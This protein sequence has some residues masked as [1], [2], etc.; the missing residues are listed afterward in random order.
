MDAPSARELLP[1]T[2]QE[3]YVRKHPLVINAPKRRAIF[4]FSCS[5]FRLQSPFWTR[6]VR[7]AY[8]SGGMCIQLWWSLDTDPAL[9]SVLLM[10]HTLSFAHVR[11]R[12][13]FF[14]IASLILFT[15]KLW[16]ICLPPSCRFTYVWVWISRTNSL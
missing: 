8:L 9:T 14:F 10:P 15:L 13:F 3:T 1:Q 12:Y 6:M 7:Y 16:P 5:W 4:F 11:M 2:Y